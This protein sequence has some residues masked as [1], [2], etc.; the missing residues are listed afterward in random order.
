MNGSRKLESPESPCSG[1]QSPSLIR[2]LQRLWL[3]NCM[4]ETQLEAKLRHRLTHTPRN[5]H[6]QRILTTP[7]VMLLLEPDGTLTAHARGSEEVLLSS[8][9]GCV[10]SFPSFHAYVKELETLT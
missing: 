8:R 2:G 3:E 5:H 10:V 7:R 6:H 9:E 1:S 4:I